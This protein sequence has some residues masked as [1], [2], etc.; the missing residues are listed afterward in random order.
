MNTW[1]S[2]L[3]D[4]LDSSWAD[5][6]IAIRLMSS[7]SC[8]TGRLERYGQPSRTESMARSAVISALMQTSQRGIF[9]WRTVDPVLSRTGGR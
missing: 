4:G 9:A 8:M 1:D 2:T 3:S 6:Q 7:G 5:V